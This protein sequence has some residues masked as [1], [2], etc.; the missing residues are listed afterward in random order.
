LVLNLY[1]SMFN[2]RDSTPDTNDVFES[3]SGVRGGVTDRKHVS[4]GRETVGGID[5]GNQPTGRANNTNLQPASA[6]RSDS[7][8]ATNH[9]SSNE[10]VGRLNSRKIIMDNAPTTETTAV[11]DEAAGVLAAVNPADAA[12]AAS[13]P[14]IINVIQGINALSSSGVVTADQSAAVIQQVIAAHAAWVAATAIKH[15]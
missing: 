3:M 8:N 9:V 13:I 10:S 12:I 14:A 5:C 7:G 1:R 6:S 15:A 4:I 2:N 11:I